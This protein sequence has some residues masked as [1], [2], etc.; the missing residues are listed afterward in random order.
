MERFLKTEVN[1]K[2]GERAWKEFLSQI[3]NTRSLNNLE[4]IFNALLSSKE[5]F[6]L[7][8]RLVVKFL[9]KQGK[10][11]KEISEILGVS[12][13]TINA[14]KK[15]LFEKSYKTYRKRKI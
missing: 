11:H 9:L 5:K 10:R 4:G 8:R 12:R 1:K 15:S 13:Q 6:L 3:K 7:I 14:V 2:L